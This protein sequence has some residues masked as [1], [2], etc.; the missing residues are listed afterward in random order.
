MKFKLKPDNRNIGEEELIADLRHVASELK[1]DSLTQGEYKKYGKFG[2]TIFWGRFGSWLNALTKA[3]L[4]SS[5]KNLRIKD[6]E[7]IND[8]K[9]V[10]FE[11]K[12]N[13]I[14]RDEYSRHGKFHSATLE[15]RFGSWIK[16]KEKAGLRRREHPSIS[17]EEY[18]KNLEE[19]WIKLSKQPHFSDMKMPFS[20]YSGSG[21]VHN[22]G[23]WR[24]ALEQFIK[25]VNKEEKPTIESENFITVEESKS[26]PILEYS[27]KEL[28]SGPIVKTPLAKRP[29]SSQ[30][31]I[32]K[33]RTKSDVNHRLRFMV[34]QRDK[35]KCKCCGR[36][37]ATDPST[38][39]HV[40]HKTAWTNGGETVS[41]NLQ[42]LCSKCNIG[43]GNLKVE[44]N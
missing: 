15:N 32:K 2:V 33:H 24:K 18:F 30:E 23:T 28:V 40:D 39:L 10:S 7:L 5:R 37:P 11:L 12:N 26:T 31:A 42:T 8:L 1:I 35:F 4:K 14:A 36:S 41:E 19:V 20:K 25:Y 34:M 3:D 16:A 38:I 21:Y 6:E 13:S 43:K 27:N 29:K 44:E 22:F 17:D 9:R